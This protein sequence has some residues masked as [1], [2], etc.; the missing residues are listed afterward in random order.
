MKTKIFKYIMFA[1]MLALGACKDEETVD[2]GISN[3]QVNMTDAP[4]PYD[5]VFVD[6]QSVE[7]TGPLGPVMLNTSAGIYNLLD[8]T[9]GN[10]TIL[11]TGSITAG[12]VSQIRLILGNNNRVVISGVSYPLSTPSAQQSGLKLQIHQTF[13][14]GVTYM[15]LLDFDAQQSIV[16]HGNGTYSLKPVIRVIEQAISG[17]IKGVVNPAVPCL[18][19]AITAADTVATATSATGAFLLQGLSAGLYTVVL[20]P[21]APLNSSTINN[22]PVTNGNVTDLGTINL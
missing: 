18:V 22:V 5:S 19:Q 10:D 20:T 3:V 11:A 2:P 17:S 9:N 6:V 4:G 8:L 21:A 16:D 15:L 14:A 12:T 1:F 7:I 13:I